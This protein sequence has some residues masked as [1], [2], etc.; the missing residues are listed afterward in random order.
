MQCFTEGFASIAIERATGGPLFF[1]DGLL[2]KERRV[3]PIDGT[4][5]EYGQCS[6]LV[7]LKFGVAKPFDNGWELA[8]AAGVAISLVTADDKVKESALFAD[9]EVNKYLS[10]GSFIG[11]GLSFWDLTRSGTFTPAWLLHFGMP[12]A[13]GAGFPVFIIAESRLF[14]DHTDDISNNYQVWGGV[15]IQFPKR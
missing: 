4:T 12:V 2:G 8:G 10:G 9:A 11:T 15:R 7:G 6:P 14:F 5:L 3:R 1:F 13:K